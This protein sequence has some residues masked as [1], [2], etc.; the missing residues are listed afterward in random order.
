MMVNDDEL[1]SAL[2]DGELEGEALDRALILLSEDDAAR[3]R[4]QRYQLA[5]NVLGGQVSGNQQ[6]DISQQISAAIADLPVY[7]SIESDEEIALIP[8]STTETA[9]VLT[10]PER[11]WKQAIGLAVAASFGAL[12]VVGTMTQPEFSAMPIASVAEGE[13]STSVIVT[14]QTQGN[15][16]SVSEQEI[17]DRL[18]VYL[19]DHNEYAGAS[20]V[21]SNARV[22]AY[23]SGR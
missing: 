9:T 11:F 22:I 20:D 14:A 13:S 15:R 18:N 16:W 3:D 5:S 7:S 23:E 8:A 10:F 19:L 1:L 2:V 17:E 6:I 21:F 4:F 12:A